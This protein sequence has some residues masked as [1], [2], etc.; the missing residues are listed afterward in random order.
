MLASGSDRGRRRRLPQA[1]DDCTRRPHS[2]RSGRVERQ[3]WLL[4]RATVTSTAAAG[5]RQQ[6]WQLQAET[7][8]N[9]DRLM[10]EK[11]QQM[12]SAARMSA[13]QEGGEDDR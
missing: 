13:A 8:S 12:V 3:G 5:R 7:D 11:N 2:K 4:V 10:K 9:S 1:A 6:E